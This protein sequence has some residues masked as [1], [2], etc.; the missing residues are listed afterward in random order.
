MRRVEDL[1]I[2]VALEEELR[3]VDEVEFI[4]K[5]DW[6]SANQTPLTQR[7]ADQHGRAKSLQKRL[8]RILSLSPF[9]KIA[10]P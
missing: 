8:L 6:L 10:Q 7:S 2:E 4:R 3:P 1:G 5:P 9:S